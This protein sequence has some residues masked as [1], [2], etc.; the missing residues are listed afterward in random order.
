MYVI[1]SEEIFDL[2]EYLQDPPQLDTTTPAI[3]P[4]GKRKVFQ[5][6]S[7]AFSRMSSPR[8]DSLEIQSTSTSDPSFPCLHPWKKRQ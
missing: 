2:T 7:S 5:S 3:S 1:M 8:G 6:I 4:N